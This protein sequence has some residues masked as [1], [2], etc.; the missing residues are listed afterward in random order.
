MNVKKVIAL[1][2]DNSVFLL[3]TF[4]FFKSTFFSVQKSCFFVTS[5]RSL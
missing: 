5:N 2:S 3:Y 1:C 4:S